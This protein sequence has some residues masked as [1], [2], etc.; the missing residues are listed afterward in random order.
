LRVLTDHTGEGVGLSAEGV[1]MKL[2]QTHFGGARPVA[3]DGD[4]PQPLVTGTAFVD[5]G[6]KPT[7]SPTYPLDVLAAFSADR[8][9]FLMSIVNPTETACSFS[10]AISGVTLRGAGMLHQIAPGNASATNQAG[11]EPAVTIVDTAVQ[12]LPASVEV[13]PVSVSLY[14]F[15]VA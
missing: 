13:P 7:G 15:D 5:R 4:S 1:V 8:K 11:K 3:V 6:T 2:M 9:T 12:A 10:P 14:A